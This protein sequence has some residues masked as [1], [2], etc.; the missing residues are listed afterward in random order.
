M[1]DAI[2]QIDGHFVLVDD[3]AF[4]DGFDDLALFFLG[5]TWSTGIEVAGFG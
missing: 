1:N 3:D 4:G 5:K 2:V